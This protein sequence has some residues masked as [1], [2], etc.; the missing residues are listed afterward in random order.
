MDGRCSLQLT[1]QAVQFIRT[2]A[3]AFFLLGGKVVSGVGAGEHNGSTRF[4][5]ETH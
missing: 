4:H 2:L 5:T 1:K 3:Y